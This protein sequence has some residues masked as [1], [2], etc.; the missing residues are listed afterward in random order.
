[1]NET[2]AIRRERD[3]ARKAA[4]RL[5]KGMIPQKNRTVMRH[6]G[7]IAETSGVSLS[8]LYRHRRA[9]TFDAFLYDPESLTKKCLTDRSDDTDRNLSD[10]GG[11]EPTQGADTYLSYPGIS[12]RLRENHART[13]EKLVSEADHARDEWLDTMPPWSML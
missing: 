9:G 3:R 1:M 11:V 5:R 6:M 12:R 4:E 8:T 2:D 7:E 10:Q 13:I